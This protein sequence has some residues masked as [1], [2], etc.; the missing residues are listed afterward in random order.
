MRQI[1]ESAR[2]AVLTQKLLNKSRDAMM[3]IPMRNHTDGRSNGQGVLT[4]KRRALWM[5]ICEL[6]FGSVDLVPEEYGEKLH[7]ILEDVLR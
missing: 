7:A 5:R 6:T 4:R 3:Q 2:R 1:A